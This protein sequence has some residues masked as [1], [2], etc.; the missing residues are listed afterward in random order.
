M[1]RIKAMVEYTFVC[2]GDPDKAQNS[3]KGQINTDLNEYYQY[4]DPNAGE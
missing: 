3:I 2:T 4:P 1:Y